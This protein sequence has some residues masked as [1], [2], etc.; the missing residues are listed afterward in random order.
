MCVC[1]CHFCGHLGKMSKEKDEMGEKARGEAGDTP[2]QAEV[3]FSVPFNSQCDDHS[4]PGTLI[5]ILFG[6]CAN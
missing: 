1:V 5:H 3:S 6:C 2:G 4:S